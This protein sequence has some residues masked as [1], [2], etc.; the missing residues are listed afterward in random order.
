MSNRTNWK[1]NYKGEQC[2]YIPVC[3]HPIKLEL[4]ERERH[5]RNWS[6]YKCCEIMVRSI[7]HHF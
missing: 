3:N 2:M 4:K 7:G 5:Q 6:H 1:N